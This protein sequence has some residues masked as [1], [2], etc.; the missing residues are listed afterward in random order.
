MSTSFIENQI[1]TILVG[2]MANKF[3]GIVALLAPELV[4][5]SFILNLILITFM[6]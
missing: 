5:N 6:M 3:E 2:I 4:V 1:I